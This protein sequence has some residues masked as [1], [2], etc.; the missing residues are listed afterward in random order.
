MRPIKV[1]ML[2]IQLGTGEVE[3]EQTRH[4]LRNSVAPSTTMYQSEQ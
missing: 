2:K 4:L 1:C 3:Q